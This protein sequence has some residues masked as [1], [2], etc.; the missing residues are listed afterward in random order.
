LSTVYEIQVIDANRAGWKSELER[1][2][3]TELRRVAL[4]RSVSVRVA[5]EPSNGDCPSIVVYLA[6]ETA[7]TDAAGDE[8]V[9]D[10]TGQG[11]VVIPVVAD[12]RAFREHVPDALAPINGFEW[13][14]GDPA[15]RLARLL[16][17]ALGIE[18]R[19]RRVFISHKREDGLGAAEQLHDGLS[20]QG[21]RPFI[22]RF[23][24]PAGARVQDYIADELEAHAFMLLVE[25][26]QAHESD[27]VF[28][29]VDYALSHTMGVLI[30]QWPGQPQPVP[31]SQGLPRLT[32]SPEQLETDEHGYDILTMEALE[33]V[34]AQVEAAHAS[35]LVRRRR[36]LVQNVEEA[37]AAS[38]CTSC[39]PLPDWRV[40]VA[41]EEQS[42]LVGVTPRLPTATDLQHLDEARGAYEA[43]PSAVLVHSA[44]TL[45]PSLREHLTWVSGA[46]D[47]S[48]TPENAIGGHWT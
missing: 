22:D 10:A 29:E 12:L 31:G 40:L 16:L 41:H 19:Q 39:V 30:L 34:M 45:R 38:G 27:W 44:R 18:E 33:E 7:P 35:G 6:A 43:P 48:L 20:H 5:G 32:L 21:F 28:D 13:S 26:P 23:A 15:E 42:T 14:G 24:I 36:M 9:R 46:R 37:A 4:H 8:R 3:E 2:V 47:L 11:L 25:T 1:A 17:E